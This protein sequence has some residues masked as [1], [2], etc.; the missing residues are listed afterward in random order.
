ML[1]H[2][3]PRSETMD[4]MSAYKAKSLGFC[5]NL[6]NNYVHIKWFRILWKYV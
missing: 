4:G 1:V 6:E 2:T 3:T 5:F